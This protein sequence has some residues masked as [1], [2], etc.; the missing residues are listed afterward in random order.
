M[1]RFSFHP[2]AWE[3]G[4]SRLEAAPTEVPRL[5]PR[6]RAPTRKRLAGAWRLGS[7]WSQGAWPL[8]PP[9]RSPLQSTGGRLGHRLPP[10]IG[11]RGRLPCPGQPSACSCSPCWP[12]AVSHAL[13]PE[14][15]EGQALYPACHVCH[16]P[17][18]D[19]PLGPPMWA[20]QRRYRN[21]S[22]DRR[23][24]RR[25]DHRLRQG[26]VAGASA[27]HAGGRAVGADARPAASGRDAAQDRRLHLGGRLRPALRALAQRRT[28]GRV[29]RRRGPRRP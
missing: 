16:D 22:L 17:T 15:S 9:H 24:L 14:A 28:M 1:A 11:P 29:H 18:L 25:A 27:H 23:G 7:N 19:P 20:V 2:P 5:S 3:R 6:C 12:R 8:P 4:R 26:A 13:S 21:A 10:P